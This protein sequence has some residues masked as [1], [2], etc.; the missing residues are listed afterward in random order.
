MRILFIVIICN[1]CIGC[2][3]P[4]TVCNADYCLTEGETLEQIGIY[5]NDKV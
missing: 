1:I 3:A 4:Q 5:K 2:S